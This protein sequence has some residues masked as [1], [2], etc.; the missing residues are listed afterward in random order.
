LEPLNDWSEFL[1][2]IDQSTAIHLASL[3]F[4][5]DPLK[6]LRERRSGEHADSGDCERCFETVH[7]KWGGGGEEFEGVFH[8]SLCRVQR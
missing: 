4:T 8:D 1:V 5:S 6:V 7:A 2:L 3:L